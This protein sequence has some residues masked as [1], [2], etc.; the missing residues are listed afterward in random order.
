[1]VIVVV[2]RVEALA[3][4]AQLSHCTVPIISREES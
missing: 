1:M 4:V 3:N 2:M